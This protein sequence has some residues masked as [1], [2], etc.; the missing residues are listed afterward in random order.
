MK[1]RT[2]WAAIALM[3]GTALATGAYAQAPTS[4]GAGTGKVLAPLAD[5]AVRPSP[6]HA[7]PPAEADPDQNLE[8]REATN[9]G[10]TLNQ[11]LASLSQPA[12]TPAVAAVSAPTPVEMIQAQQ[13]QEAQ[14]QQVQ[15]QA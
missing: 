8:Q 6:I 11:Q 10:D 12:A 5:T 4:S 15:A 2:C 9:P 14:A 13:A 3:A 1:R 7:L